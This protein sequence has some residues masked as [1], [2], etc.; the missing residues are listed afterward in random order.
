MKEYWNKFKEFRKDPKK[1]SISL[2]IIYGIFFIFVFVYLKASTPINVPDYSNTN[3][4]N[5]LNEVTSYEYTYEII[6]NDLSFKINGMYY[7][8][9]N[10]ISFDNDYVM[11]D[12]YIYVNDNFKIKFD[13][14]NNKLNY[15]N[16][17]NFVSNYQYD[18]KTEYKDN[19]IKYIYN[20]S[21]NDLKDYLNE[22]YVGEDSSIF[23]VYEKDYFYKVE[24]DLSNFYK[25]DKYIIN[26]EYNNVNNINNVET[27]EDVNNINNN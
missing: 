5:N 23:T 17:K 1:K 10:K 27:K 24:I 7:N 15:N 25:E 8:S 6:K 2:L 22:E 20:I 16:F 19:T 14:L 4:S 18:S 26:I 12:D 13:I 3:I 9:E 21:N 11:K